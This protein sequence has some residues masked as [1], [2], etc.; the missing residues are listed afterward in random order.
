MFR[1]SHVRHGAT[2][3]RAILRGSKQI[4]IVKRRTLLPKGL[5]SDTIKSAISQNLKE[6]EYV[7]PLQPARNLIRKNSKNSSSSVQN[8][9]MSYIY[10]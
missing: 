1:R 3:M 2:N 10:L 9:G 5:S 7:I 6:D 4:I 8:D